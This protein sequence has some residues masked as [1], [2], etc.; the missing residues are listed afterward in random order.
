MTRQELEKKL[1]ELKKR[2]FFLA[3]K[4]RWTASDFELDRKISEEI[5]KTEEELKNVK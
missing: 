3:M 5:R 1:E 4:D 2:E